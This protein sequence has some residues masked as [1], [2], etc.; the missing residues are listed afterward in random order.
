MASQGRSPAGCRDF[1]VHCTLTEMTWDTT[2]DVRRVPRS[3]IVV[4]TFVF[5]AF[6]IRWGKELKFKQKYGNSKKENLAGV[7]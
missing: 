3:S 4:P 5:G 2:L 7:F 6:L 1:S